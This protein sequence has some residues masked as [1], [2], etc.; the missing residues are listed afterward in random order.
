MCILVVHMIPELGL[1][2]CCTELAQATFFC[3]QKGRLGLSFHGGCIIGSYLRCATASGIV[4]CMVFCRV[5]LF[6]LGVRHKV[7]CHWDSSQGLG[8]KTHW[9][10]WGT[11]QGKIFIYYLTRPYQ[12]TNQPPFFRL[13]MLTTFRNLLLPHRTLILHLHCQKTG[14]PL[15]PKGIHK[16]CA[17]ETSAMLSENRQWPQP[18]WCIG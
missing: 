6:V 10:H 2:L 7:A 16:R 13:Y 12:L 1:V 3:S 5:G 11:L 8:V 14:S 9:Q 18:I 15:L 4:A 17:S